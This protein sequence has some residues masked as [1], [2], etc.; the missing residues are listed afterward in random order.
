[1]IGW[2]QFCPFEDLEFPEE[3]WDKCFAINIKAHVW[4]LKAALP[5]FKKN[6]DGGHLLITGSIAVF[7]MKTTL[8][9][10]YRCWWEFYGTSY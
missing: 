8:T 10:G 1:L 7:L 2:T 6:D 9:V 3:A 5:T 4:L